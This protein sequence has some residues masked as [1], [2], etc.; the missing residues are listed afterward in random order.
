MKT[1]SVF[2]SLLLI[3]V[4]VFFAAGWSFLL[5]RLATLV[6]IA[7]MAEQIVMSFFH[8]R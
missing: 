3:A 8:K 5:G 4:R 1:F 2:K 7:Q 6:K